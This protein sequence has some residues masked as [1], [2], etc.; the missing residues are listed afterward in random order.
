MTVVAMTT[1]APPSGSTYR[2]I[3]PRAFIILQGTSPPPPIHPSS[4]PTFPPENG[5]TFPV[6]LAAVLNPI[7]L[8]D[9]RFSKGGGGGVSWRRRREDVF[10]DPGENLAEMKEGSWKWKNEYSK[11][12]HKASTVLHNSR[13]PPQ[14]A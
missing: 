3:I 12:T 4:H 14:S 2:P 13:R 7:R 1:A 11:R 10:I 5:Y 9:E 6:S 8:P